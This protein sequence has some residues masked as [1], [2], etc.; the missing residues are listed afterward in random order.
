MAIW[1]G[2]NNTI[3]QGTAVQ[4]TVTAPAGLTISSIYIPHMYSQGID[5]GTGWG[6]GFYW[7]GGT[8]G[9]PTFDGETSWSSAYTGSP[10]FSWPAGGTPYFGWQVVCGF[11]QC[12]NGGDQWL[13]LELLEVHVTETVGPALAAPDGLW[14]SSGWIRGTWPLHYGADSPSGVC[15]LSASLNG[16]A[17]PGSSSA[18]SPALWHQCAAPAVDTPIDTSQFGNG[19]E[20]LSLSALDAA[21]N[22]AAV[23]KT[24]Y[25]DNQTPTVSLS[26]PTDAPTTAGIQYVK[27]TATAG[28]SGVAGI[29]CSVDGAPTSWYPTPTAEIAVQGLG[30]HHISRTSEN[31]ARDTAGNAA[32]SSPATGT[33]SIRQPAFSTVSFERTVDAMRCSRVRERVRIPA[34]WVTAYSHGQAVQVKL[35]AQTRIV[36]VTR[37]HPRVIVRRV[38]VDGRWKTVRTVQLPHEALVTTKH[39]RSGQGATVSGWLGTSNGDALSNRSITVLTAPGDGT[40]S[41][42]SPAA[43]ATTG[44]DGAWTARLPPGPSRVVVAEYGGDTTIEPAA[45]A[46]VHLVVP[47]S[48]ALRIRPHR[49]HWGGRIAIRG[50]LNGGYIPPGGELVVLWVGWPGGSTEVGHLY[51]LA[52]GRFASHY[53]FLRGNGTEHYRF[54]AASARESDYPFAPGRSRAVGVTVR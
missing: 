38:R 48:L 22:P 5:D 42:F 39:V 7:Q 29:S 53:T 50:S 44:G 35:R 1:T 8:A 32:F 28:P 13:S 36:K 54:W 33:L 12:S 14:Q 6:G 47:A 34:H 11:S 20:N 40:Q 15:Q 18:H 9:V 4:W 17:L 43:T 30:V 23:N 41:Q 24:V 45:S 10:T 31:T 52:D 26:G 51:T 16:Q 25:I 49:T 21:S 37:C 46:P 2:A 27:A 3:P 19:S